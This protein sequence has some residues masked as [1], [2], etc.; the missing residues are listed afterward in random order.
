MTDESDDQ[1]GRL[2]KLWLRAADWLGIDRSP[3][4]DLLTTDPARHFKEWDRDLPERE[5]G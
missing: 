2:R 1:P 4:V 5:W 3:P